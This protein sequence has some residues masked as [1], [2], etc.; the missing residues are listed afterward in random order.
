MAARARLLH[1]DVPRQHEELSGLVPPARVHRR[2]PA[3]AGELAFV[4]RVLQEDSKNYHAWGHRQWVLKTFNLWE[5]ELLYVDQ[6]LQQDLRNNSAWNQRYFV[7][8]HTSDLKGDLELLKRE[9]DTALLHIARAPSNP[10]PWAYLRG[11]AEPVG[12]S[13]LPQV[14]APRAR[15]S[16]RRRRRRRR[17]RTRARRV[18]VVVAR[19]APGRAWRRWPYSST[20][21]SSQT[22]RSATRSARVSSAS[23]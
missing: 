1:G 14:R 4:G 13:K 7:L 19:R 18:V 12:Y 2:A 20:S 22:A 11:I 16:G 3:A 10:S 17:R 15:S 23:S 6:L 5:G 21:S 8:Q 9:A